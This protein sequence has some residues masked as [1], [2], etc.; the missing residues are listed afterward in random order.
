MPAKRQD[1]ETLGRR[2][3]DLKAEAEALTHRYART[4]WFRFFLVFFPVP[5]VVLLLRFRIEGWHYMVA[6]GAYVVFSA[7]LYMIDGRAS[8]KCD[9]AVRAAGRAQQDYEIAQHLARRAA[10]G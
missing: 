7:I 3:A 5:F 9:E 2:A 8:A 1:I 6:G 4:T 10:A